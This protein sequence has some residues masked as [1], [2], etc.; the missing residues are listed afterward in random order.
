MKPQTATPAWKSFLNAFPGLTPVVI[1]QWFMLAALDLSMAS[2]LIIEMAL[3]AAGLVI[4]RFRALAELE[5]QITILPPFSA[6][7][8]CVTV[9]HPKSANF[10]KAA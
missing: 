9:V 10:Q 6:E 5:L 1:L 8:P 2:C 3:V 4:C 7:G